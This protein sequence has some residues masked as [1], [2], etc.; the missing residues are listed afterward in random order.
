[1]EDFVSE[2]RDSSVSETS[3]VSAKSIKNDIDDIECD[4]PFY[5]K[6]K[7]EG[8]QKGLDLNSLTN[9]IVSQDST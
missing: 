2:D 7:K 3:S 9:N 5:N 8:K 4:V 6:T 1:M